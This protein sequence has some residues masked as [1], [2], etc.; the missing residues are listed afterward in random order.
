MALSKYI[1]EKEKK[2]Q[3]KTNPNHHNPVTKKSAFVEIWLQYENH[4]YMKNY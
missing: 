1:N 2:Q 3:N 4:S